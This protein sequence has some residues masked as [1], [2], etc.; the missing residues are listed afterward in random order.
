MHLKYQVVV[1]TPVVSIESPLLNEFG[2]VLIYIKERFPAIYNVD[3]SYFDEWDGTP[4]SI[5]YEDRPARIEM[6]RLSELVERKECVYL[7]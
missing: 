5:M 6:R 1:H 7:D 2:D 4:V 3:Q